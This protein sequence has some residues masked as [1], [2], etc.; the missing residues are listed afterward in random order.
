ML[1]TGFAAFDHVL[2]NLELARLGRLEHIQY[3]VTFNR[4]NPSEQKHYNNISAVVL[5]SLGFDDVSLYFLSVERSI[6][7]GISRLLCCSHSV[8]RSLGF[9][10]LQSF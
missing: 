5:L 9:R 1:A 7:E 4:R 3:G 10:V 6:N 8:T 2:Y